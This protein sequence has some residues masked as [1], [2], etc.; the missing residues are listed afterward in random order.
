MTEIHKD[1]WSA[2]RYNKAAS[3]VYSD[4]NTQT[5]LDLLAPQPGERIMDLGCGS[6]ELTFRLQEIVGEDGI[7]VGVDASRDM[8]RHTY[9]MRL[10]TNMGQSW[11]KLKRMGFKN[12]CVAICRSL[13]CP[14]S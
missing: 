9:Y 1:T 8:V 11:R 3:F 7:V 14:R 12:S 2:E 10:R 13:L 5:V 6:G 4:A